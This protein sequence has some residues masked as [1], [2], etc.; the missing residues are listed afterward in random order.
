MSLRQRLEIRQGQTLVM[1]PQMQQ[2]IRLLQMSNIE[3]QAFVEAELER[4][5]LLERTELEEPENRRREPDQEPSDAPEGRDDAEIAKEVEDLSEA[6]SGPADVGERMA[7]LDA[8]VSEMFS[9]D[10]PQDLPSPA[11][12]GM[13]DSG[14]SALGGG[15]GGMIPEGEGRSLEETVG[16][17]TTLAAHLEEQ[18]P[19]VIEDP[20]M[21]IIGHHLIGLLDE[22]GY[23]REPLEAVAE[24]LG[25]P[26]ELVER[27]LERMQTMDP[28]GVFA[29]D[30]RECL[31]LQLRERDRLD[32][33][34]EKLVDN[35][36]LLA[37]RDFDRLRRIC[38]VGDEDLRD[39]LEEIR[40][41]NP[42]PGGVIGPLTVQPV[43]PDVFVR[44]A[45]DGSWIVELNTETLPRVLV[46]NSYYAMVQASATREEDREYISACMNSANWLVRS[47]D[48]RA[49]TIL[50]VAREIVRQQDAF[51][52]KGVE[53]LRPLTLKQVAEAIGMHESTVSRVTS[54][55][56]MA[57]PR[58]VF[59]M[60]YFFTTAI[61][62][63][64]GG[65][66]VSA[67]SVRHRIR[68]LIDAEDP[69]KVLSDDKIVDILRSEGIEIARRTVAKYREAMGIPSSLQRRREKKL[70]AG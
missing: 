65:E 19:L 61:T 55:K 26:L 53:A 14:W 48:Q 70:L 57:T 35:L 54:N 38:G 4:N 43:V 49:R 16:S 31:M 66:A 40:A 5:P 42:R 58:G 59:E 52:T 44:M 11:P 56:Y 51:L 24:Q 34:M 41:L 39:M 12:E 15:S 27:T 50:A 33:A 23:M 1:T 3:L 9:S 63:S 36:E 45:P 32:P 6:M 2:A 60:K 7:E 37:A 62:T 10:S 20:A 21:R 30:L 68:Q 29:R 18:L 17:E 69:K 47:L 13:R 28:P 64:A 22:A 8:D 25:A 67:E 46:N